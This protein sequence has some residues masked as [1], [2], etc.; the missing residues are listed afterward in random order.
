M[1]IWIKVC[2]PS[3]KQVSGHYAKVFRNILLFRKLPITLKK[4]LMEDVKR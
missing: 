1:H 4:L 3:L 2:K